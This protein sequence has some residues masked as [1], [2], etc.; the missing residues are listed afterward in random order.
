MTRATRARAVVAGGGIVALAA[1][2]IAVSGGA[3]SLA[4]AADPPAVVQAEGLVNQAA[5]DAFDAASVAPAGKAAAVRASKLSGPVPLPAGEAFDDIDWST[6]P[7]SDADIE[8]LLEFNAAC[9]WWIADADAPTKVTARVVAS[10]PSWPTM[11]G[12]DRHGLALA[13]TGADGKL[14]A[15]AL[16]YCRRS[17]G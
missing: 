13:F 1:V 11:R 9:K 3:A 5:P 10:I 8:G 7:V 15:Q 17:V 4:S 16:D 2:A 6:A 12:G 14:A